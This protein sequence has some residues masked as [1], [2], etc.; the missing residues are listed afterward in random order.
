MSPQHL[1]HVASLRQ[2]IV[3]EWLLNGVWVRVGACVWVHVG[4]CGCVW[5]HMYGC[6]GAWECGAW[7]CGV[8]AASR[9]PEGFKF[10]GIDAVA[11]VVNCPF[12]PPKRGC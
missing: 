12:S 8:G 3:L 6:M 10:V 1:L 7:V 2:G 11:A 5:V 4:A 9:R